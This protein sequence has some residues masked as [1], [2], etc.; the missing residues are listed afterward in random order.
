MVYKDS[1]IMKLSP[2]VSGCAILYVKKENRC[3]ARS[4]NTSHQRLIFTTDPSS[5]V[6]AHSTILGAREG[7]STVAVMQNRPHSKS[8]RTP[9]IFVIKPS[10]APPMA[11][12][13]D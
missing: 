13:T 2:P 1:R 7:I 5:T 3:D 8:H 4:D 6:H 11:S 9:A 12:C 10:K